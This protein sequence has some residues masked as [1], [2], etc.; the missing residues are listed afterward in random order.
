MKI[1][2]E[3][4]LRRRLNHQVVSKVHHPVKKK[5]NLVKNQKKRRKTEKYF[6]KERGAGSVI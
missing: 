3:Q 1:K 4:R 5:R 6:L 2:R